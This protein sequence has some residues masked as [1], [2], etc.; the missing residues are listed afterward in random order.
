MTLD[1]AGLPVHYIDLP[2]EPEAPEKGCILFLHG[3][4]APITLYSQ[5]FDHLVR[6]GYR[7][8][9][10]DMPGVGQTPEPAAPLTVADYVSLTLAVCRQLGL[11]SCTIMCHSHGGRIALS[12]LGDPQCPVRCDRAVLIDA[13]GVVP[14]KP[15]AARLRQMGYKAAKAL[16][17]A[18]LTA[19]LFGPLY[20]DMR[21]R[22]ASADYKAASPIMRQTMN[23]VLPADF[24][25]LMPGIRAEVLLI[26]GDRDTAT[27]LD[28]GQTMARLMPNAGL[29]VIQNAGHFSFADNW[30]QFSAV[31][32]AFL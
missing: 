31:L 27:P 7:V 29:A 24:T 22:R 10:F 1:I 17:T 2:P 30:P 20:E 12:M 9:A 11:E 25:H 14:P 6:R 4:A 5:I 8:V 23:Q 21:D 28:R 26:W 3:W 32:D 19:P 15:A 18:R 13:T 16:G